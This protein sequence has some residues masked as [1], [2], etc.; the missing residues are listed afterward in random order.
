MAKYIDLNGLA[1]VFGKVKSLVSSAVAGKADKDLSNVDKTTLAN[2]L[3]D[4]YLPLSGGKMTGVLQATKVLFDRSNGANGDGGIYKNN[5]TGDGSTQIMDRGTNNKVGILTLNGSTHKLSW[6]VG[7]Q[8]ADGNTTVES[9]NEIYHEGNKPSADD[10]GALPKTGGELTGPVTMKSSGGYLEIQDTDSGGGTKLHKNAAASADYGT[11]LADVAADGTRDVLILRRAASGGQK[12]QLAIAQADG[13]SEAYEI[14]GEHNKPTAAD[15]GAGT[16]AGQVVANA[17]GQTPG[18][19]LLRNSKLAT[20][21][22]T[23]TNNGEII[24]VYE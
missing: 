13:T 10:V 4:K 16:F 3:N 2:A 17:S 20:A 23:P 18:T 7:Q 15:V 9:A 12:L 14:Y 1:Y 6:S 19:S 8:T 24:W 22:G 21:E 11:Y 5:E